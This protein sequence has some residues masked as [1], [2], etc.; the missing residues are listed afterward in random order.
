MTRLLR[1]LAATTA[2]LALVGCS[3][4]S[5]YVFDSDSGRLTATLI[6]RAERSFE[7]GIS[8]PRFY[9]GLQTWLHDFPEDCPS[10]F[11]GLSR[12]SESSLG[13]IKHTGVHRDLRV[14]IPAEGFFVVRSSWYRLGAGSGSACTLNVGFF[15]SVGKNYHFHLRVDRRECFVEFTDESGDPVPMMDEQD[16]TAMR[17]RINEPA[18]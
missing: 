17:S 2:T 3:L 11:G 4:S 14:T 9:G 8:L 15:P 10:D 13:S 7:L 5:P 12:W 16:C 6:H 1:A 18:N